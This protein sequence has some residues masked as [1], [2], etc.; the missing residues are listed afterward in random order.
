V[1]FCGG[2]SPRCRHWLSLLSGIVR[3]DFK[4]RP[5]RAPNVGTNNRR[6]FIPEHEGMRQ[7]VKV[8]KMG[9]RQ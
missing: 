7:G 8:L 4:L 3:V 6:L 2:H 1:D 9:E 5:R